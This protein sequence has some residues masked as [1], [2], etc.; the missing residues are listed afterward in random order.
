MP[1]AMG[2]WPGR[3]K[4][5]GEGSPSVQRLDRKWQLAPDMGWAS[6]NMNKSK[7]IFD[8]LPE[9]QVCFGSPFHVLRNDNGVVND[10]GSCLGATVIK[11]DFAGNSYRALQ[12]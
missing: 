5:L 7:K 10:F 11:S 3:G 6:R 9:L 1:W 2:N 4:V 12:V 8:I